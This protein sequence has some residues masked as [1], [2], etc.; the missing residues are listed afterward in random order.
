MSHLTLRNINQL[1]TTKRVDALAS[2]ILRQ[3]DAFSRNLS[4]IQLKTR[5][6]LEVWFPAISDLIMKNN[7]YYYVVGSKKI[8]LTLPP[9]APAGTRQRIVGYSDAGWRILQGAGQQIRHGTK[10]TTSGVKGLLESTFGTDSIGL[11]CIQDNT[12]WVVSNG[13]EGRVNFV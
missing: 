9:V 11:L 1:P 4:A 12:I 3:C 5:A 7:I 13:P 10:A 8:N 2:F 6:S